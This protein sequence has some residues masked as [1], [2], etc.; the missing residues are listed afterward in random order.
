MDNDKYGLHDVL[1]GVQG[2]DAIMATDMQIINDQMP[3]RII[4]T[5]GETVVA[6]EALYQ[7]A[8]DSKWWKAKADGAKQPCQGLAV[9]GGD[10][11]D[12]IRIHRMGEITNVSWAWAT[13]GAAIYLDPSTEGAL[14]QTPPADNVQIIGYA[15]AATIMIVMIQVVGTGTVMVHALGGDAHSAD[16]KANLDNKISDGDLF[17]TLPGEIN[18]LTEK[19][20]PV[21]TDLL[22]IEDSEADN[23]KMKVQ[24]ANLPAGIPA[25]HALGGDQ[26]TADSKANLDS[27]LTDATLISTL[28]GEIAVLE[29]KI[30]LDADDVILAEDSADDNEKVMVKAS[31]LPGAVFSQG[32]TIYKSDGIVD[33]ANIIIWEAPFACTVTNVK[34]Y[35]VGGTGATINA[36]KN[37]ASNH[38]SSNLSLSSTDAWEDGGVVQNTA[39]AIEDKL[40]IMLV[41]VAGNPTQIAIKVNFKRP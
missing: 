9:E 34:G 13:I 32:G 14:T 22:L 28:P 17:S 3:T 5:L 16:L 30:I 4:G 2:W 40:E 24:I 31:N 26:H 6:Y 8:A 18:I 41:S 36:R 15:K 7:K 1:Y 39:Y 25:P 19:D 20:V 21:G 23:A 35:R 27:K 38:L 37:G 11:D 33:A 29:E 12:E 10:A